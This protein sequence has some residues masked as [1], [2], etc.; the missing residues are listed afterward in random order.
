MGDPQNY[1]SKEEVE[2]WK[3]RDPIQ[4][5]RARMTAEGTLAASEMDAIDAEITKA[6]AEAVEFARR[7]PEPDIETALQDI[8]T[9]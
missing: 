6:M 1:R 4:L 5:F 3:K 2:E 9:E 7:S 8:F